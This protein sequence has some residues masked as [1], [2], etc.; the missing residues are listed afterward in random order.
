MAII[1]DL[2]GLALVVLAWFNPLG[3]T[4]LFRIVL[5]ILGFDMMTMI[6]KVG[7]FAMNYF[8]PTFGDIFGY[9]SYT[10]LFLFLSELIIM[11]LHLDVPFN[12]FIKPL[13]VF[14]TTLLALGPIY[15]TQ[16]A[17]VAVGIDLL[18]NLSHKFKL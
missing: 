4:F 2:I 13:A 14:V 12:L 1:R 7:L 11:L 5:F 16:P 17:F 8:F 18:L 9:L 10:L 15:G 6:P 3:V